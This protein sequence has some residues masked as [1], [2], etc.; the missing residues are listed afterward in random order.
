MGCLLVDYD[1]VGCLTVGHQTPGV[2]SSD[3]GWS[4]GGEPSPGGLSPCGVPGGWSFAGALY[5]GAS[6]RSA[7][8]SSLG[9]STGRDLRMT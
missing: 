2:L 7:G 5:P 1:L 9:G 3:A 6:W 8:G 4:P